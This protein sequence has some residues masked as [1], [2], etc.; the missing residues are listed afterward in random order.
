M[1][2]ETKDNIVFAASMVLTAGTSL[3]LGTM[4][5]W[6]ATALISIVFPNGLTRAQLNL[7][8]AIIGVGTAGLT[9]TIANEIHPKFE[10]YFEELMDTFPTTVEVKNVN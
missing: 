3:M 5:G 2:K 1:K 9:L 8:G 6:G 10:N 4:A 7:F